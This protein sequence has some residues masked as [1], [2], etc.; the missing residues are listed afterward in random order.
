MLGPKAADVGDSSRLFTIPSPDRGSPAYWS[1]GWCEFLARFTLTVGGLV[2]RRKLY[3]VEQTVVARVAG[4][5]R[6]ETPQ[7]D[8]I[9]D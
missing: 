8:P 2:M 4:R 3:S 5:A 9:V 6:G 1:Q 7:R